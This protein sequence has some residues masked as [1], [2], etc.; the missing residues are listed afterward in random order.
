VRHGAA[1]EDSVAQVFSICGY[2]VVGRR[3][4]IGDAG[5]VDLWL[6]SPTGLEFFVECKGSYQGPRP[7]LMRTDTVDKAIAR[8]LRLASLADQGPLLLVTSHLPQG[9]VAAHNLDWLCRSV[10]LTVLQLSPA[11]ELLCLAQHVLAAASTAGGKP[12]T[13]PVFLRTE[14]V[15]FT[16]G[17]GL[18]GMLALRGLTP[19]QYQ[20]LLTRQMTEIAQGTAKRRGPWQPR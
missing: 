19:L 7:G 4:W 3:V 15:L 13:V 9:G 6:R 12:G 8:C 14:E 10:P 18:E 5:E 17:Y 2:T 20:S 11:R 16:I 1:F